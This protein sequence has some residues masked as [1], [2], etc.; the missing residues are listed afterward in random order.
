VL[1]ALVRPIAQIPIPTASVLVERD[2]VVEIPCLPKIW[3]D[4]CFDLILLPT[5]A[6][7]ANTNMIGSIRLL[8]G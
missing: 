7:A 4:S 2:F 3:D 5:G 8:D 6:A 1:V